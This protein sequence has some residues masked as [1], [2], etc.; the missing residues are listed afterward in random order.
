MAAP[1]Y[2]ASIGASATAGTGDRTIAFTPNVG[3]LAVLLISLAANTETPTVTDNQGGTYI[4]IR[5]QLWGAGAN[6][7]LVYVRDA[8]AAA[9]VVHTVTVDTT[10][11]DAGLIVALAMNNFGKVGAAAVRQSGGQSNGAAAT[12]PEP[13]IP[14][15]ALT[16]NPTIVAITSAD[17]TN[18]LPANW[19]QRQNP[20]TTV[21]TFSMVVATRNSGFTGTSAQWQTQPDQEYATVLVE[22]D[23]DFPVGGAWTA[24]ATFDATITAEQDDAP[25]AGS[26]SATATFEGTLLGEGA[27]AG[28]WAGTCSASGTLGG[29][30]AIAGSFACSS[31]FEGELDATIAAQGTFAAT[32]SFAGTLQAD[33]ELIGSWGGT[34]TFEGTAIDGGDPAPTFDGPGTTR[35][36][37]APASTT[38]TSNAADTLTRSTPTTSRRTTSPAA[39]RRE[40]DMGRTWYIN[41]DDEAGALIEQIVRPAYTESDGTLVP[42]QAIDISEAAVELEWWDGNSWETIAGTGVITDSGEEDSEAGTIYQVAFT[43]DEDATAAIPAGKHPRR[44]VFS[45]VAGSQ[46]LRVPERGH[47]RLSVNAD[48]S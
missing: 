45:W 5:Q 34:A 12:T 42:L 25:I 35:H 14:V 18:T 26:W 41:A 2:R 39:T 36:T 23:G 20:Q 40:L 7:L 10:S 3:D 6:N 8:L 46:Q 1:A 17:V 37:T 48:P 44:W 19:T 32:S 22:L 16:R 24:L 28:T 13:T 29:V 33:G 30:A 47:D 15:A 31:T 38:T 27:L 4:F 21:P 43:R 11:N 9:A